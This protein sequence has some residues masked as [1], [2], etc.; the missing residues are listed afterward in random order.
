FPP[1]L[2]A[3]GYYTAENAINWLD[4]DKF[5]GW[6]SRS[7][8]ST[9]VP[10]PS[11]PIHAA[12]SVP[13][14]PL[15]SLQHSAPSV[16]SS[17]IPPSSPTHSG[18]HL[19]ISGSQQTSRRSSSTPC[20]SRGPL[21]EEG[22][23][24]YLLDMQ[25][26]SREWLDKDGQPL[27]MVAIIK[28]EDQDAWGQGTGG[29][30]R[31]PTKVAA[32]D[33]ALCQVA[34]HICQGVYTCSEFDQ[35]LMA[36]HERYEPDDEAMRE[37][38]EADRAVNVR[39][40]SSSA[41]RAAAFYSEVHSDKKHCPFIRPD[42]T[43]CDGEPV[44]R[45]LRETNFDGKNGF[46]GCQHFA[47]GQ[48][49]RFVTINRDVDEALVRELFQNNGRF[50]SFVNVVSAKCARVLP[51]RQGGKGD[52]K[53]PYTHI[54]INGNVIQGNIIRRPCTTT[55][56]IFAPIDRSDRR[57]I[58]YLS[59]PHN[60]PRPPS[61]K[62]SRKGKDTYQTAIL[63]AGTTA[64]TVLK[65]DNAGSTSKIF[66]GKVP[67]SLDPALANPRIKRKLI[68]DMKTVDNPH[69]LGWEG[70]CFFEQK[71]RD[72]L[73]TEKRYIQYLIS[74]DGV[75]LVLTMLPYLASRI[76]FCKASLHDNTYARLH[77]VWKEWEVVIWDDKFDARATI[78][79]AYSKHET[80]EVFAKMWPA[81]FNTIERVTG[82]EVKFKFIHG[83]GLRTVLV[84]GNKAQA[85]A[86]GADLVA[87][88]KPHLS[89]IYERNPKKILKYCLRTCTIHIQR[90]FTDLA[91][92]VPDEDM[93]RICRCLF[94]KTNDDLEDFI[95]WCKNSKY[96]VVQDWI[97]DK[98]SITDWFWSSINEFLSEIPKE[99]WLLTP[100]DTNLNESAHP[101]TNQHTGTNL[102]LLVAIQTAYKLDLETEA[103]FKL[104]E[105]E[106][107]LVNPNNSKAKRDRKNASRRE[108]H[109]RH[110]LERNDA[111][112]ELEEI[113]LALEQEAEARKA[114]NIFTKELRERKKSIQA[115]SG[116]KKTK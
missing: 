59:G 112:C 52:R 16:H 48:K 61:T 27:S 18:S 62:L 31:K 107:V 44:Y 115:A 76:H 29:S 10:M 102:P 92:V 63:S 47:Q 35:S 11:T 86:L 116:V 15:I 99:D 111:R 40:T 87:R 5:M 74:E 34:S 70:V 89:G 22:D 100:G 113:D 46:I 9:A 96:K 95:Q 20:T 6:L 97:K 50:T 90:K 94:L 106:C 25:Q 78:A 28:S 108:T 55:I 69:G 105:K 51:P 8:Q 71:M 56:K 14:A 43:P 17:P 101:Y 33:D 30:V 109:H 57:A 36:G 75:Q 66:G 81:L 58:I 13:P 68:Y 53:C 110:A 93:G 72:T 84:D 42:G 24:A 4:I 88:N 65:C 77:G 26:D 32:L 82:V 98:D 104:M 7:I 85:N 83:E 1:P 64:L 38:W 41:I 73:P 45:P 114:S 19:K 2:V 103:K 37:L 60:H 91:K 79:R 23:F 3:L 54:D 21:G 67:A 49:H 12:V 39:D 80:Y